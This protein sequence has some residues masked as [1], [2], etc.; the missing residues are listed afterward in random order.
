MFIADDFLYPAWEKLLRSLL[1]RGQEISPRQMVTKE[2]LAV[3]FRVNLGRHNILYH[4]T[5]A[6]N[7][8]F[9]TAEWL[10]IVSGSNDL[11]E[12]AKFNSELRKFSDD[13]VVLYGAYGPRLGAQLKW[14]RDRL[15]TDNSTRQAVATIW[16]PFER[17][18]KDIPC[19][20]AL[21][22]LLRQDKLN[23]IVTMRSSDAWLGLPYDFF[24]FSQIL[25]SMAGQLLCDVG[26][27]QFNLG[28]SHL[29]DINLVQAQRIIDEGSRGYTF[30]SPRLTS[31]PPEALLDAFRN[32]NVPHN[33]N[34]LPWSIY[35]NV[36]L[37]PRSDA[38]QYLTSHP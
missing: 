29:Y 13:G 16:M 17:E 3:G 6:L 35:A 38:I 8:K 15:L 20:V 30:T 24:V 9:M 23:L 12:I 2:V 31:S 34:S 10:W 4:P 36:L 37:S 14:V 7:Y 19:T 5:R 1:N 21:Q 27:V 25:N 33:V 28:S 18:S 11:E 26:F 32:P 22:F